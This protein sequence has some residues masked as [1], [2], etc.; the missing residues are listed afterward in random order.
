MSPLTVD[1]VH[2]AAGNCVLEDIE[3]TRSRIIT[4]A[5]VLG[6]SGR[7]ADLRTVLAV[8]LEIEH[9]VFVDQTLRR[10]LAEVL[11]VDLPALELSV[12]RYE[13]GGGG[14]GV[15]RA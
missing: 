7:K 6:A 3:H 10:D 1:I 13:N 8:Y 14:S 15:E 2:V 12:A 9:P 4:S 5:D 11:V